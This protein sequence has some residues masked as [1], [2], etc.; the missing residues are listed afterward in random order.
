MKPQRCV[1]R[2]AAAVF[3]VVVTATA[4]STKEELPPPAQTRAVE[5]LFEPPALVVPPG[6]PTGCEAKVETRA[7]R[8]VM[9]LA[10][11]LPPAPENPLPGECHAPRE[12]WVHLRAGAVVAVRSPP[13]WVHRV[14]TLDG[15]DWTVR[16]WTTPHVRPAVVQGFSIST[17][18]RGRV[19]GWGL[20]FQNGIIIWD[21]DVESYSK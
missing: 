6:P 3:S 21:F 5:A 11:H 10:M 2:Q 16:W 17:R 15:A 9:T 12:L 20:E 8:D 13:G 7:E 4:C 19:L 1:M 14:P 18:G